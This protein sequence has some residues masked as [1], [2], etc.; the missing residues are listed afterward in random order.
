MSTDATENALPL[1]P[2]PQKQVAWKKFLIAGGCTVVFEASCG[3]ALEYLKISKQVAAQ[4]ASYRT[5]IKGITGTRGPIAIMDGFVP[6]GAVQALCKGAVFGGA[7]VFAKSMMS[8]V[9]MNAEFRNTLAG[10]IAGFCQ[11]IVLSPLLLLKT[12]VMT[13]ETYRQASALQQLKMS[14]KLGMKVISEGEIMKGSLVFAG[15]RFADWTTRYY[16]AGL[17][18]RVMFGGNTKLSQKQKILGGLAGGFLSTCVTIPI[19]VLVAQFQQT[20]SAGKKLSVKESLIANLKSG[21]M[22]SGFFARVTHVAL[23]TALLRTATTS[24]YDWIS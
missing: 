13:N 8:K 2:P 10:G 9:D 12:R 3:H 1:V 23:T 16:F 15:K 19:D 4:D 11:G 5:V 18:E 24:V 21:R 22:V 17:S 14:G 6:W 20:G 7:E